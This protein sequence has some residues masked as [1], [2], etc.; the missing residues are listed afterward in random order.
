MGS[1]GGWGAREFFEAEWEPQSRIGAAST[2]ALLCLPFPQSRRLWLRGREDRCWCCCTAI[3][4]PYKSRLGCV[5][6]SLMML[7]GCSWSTQRDDRQNVLH[8]SVHFYHLLGKTLHQGYVE[9]L[10]I[11]HFYRWRPQGLDGAVAPRYQQ[12][13]RVP[14][15]LDLFVSLDIKQGKKCS[16]TTPRES[17]AV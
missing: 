1:C 12:A 17:F 11:H 5:P 2:P 4:P 15:M 8:G 6:R 7:Y 9:T 10:G 3:I 16:L 14:Q 13:V